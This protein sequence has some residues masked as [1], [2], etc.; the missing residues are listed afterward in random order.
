MNNRIAIGV[1]ASVIAAVAAPRVGAAAP[2]TAP[3]NASAWNGVWLFDRADFH[4]VKDGVGQWRA[5]LSTVWDSQVTIRD[6]AFIFSHWY[7]ISKDVK[8]TIILDPAGP[9]SVDLKIESIDLGE[10]FAGVSYPAC[11]LPGIYQIEGDRLLVCC[12]FGSNPRRPSDFRAATEGTLEGTLV[13]Q[14]VKADADF[15]GFSKAV[16][17]SV[18]DPGGKPVPG[19]SICIHMG[20]HQGKN[21][22]DKMTYGYD[23]IAKTDANGIAHVSYDDLR[24]NNVLV[25]DEAHK[26]MGIASVTPVSLEKLAVTVQLHPECLLTGKIERG[27][28]PGGGENSMWTNVILEYGGEQ[29]AACES[30]SGG[31]ESRG[32]RAHGTVDA[33]WPIALQ[34]IRGHLGVVVQERCG[35]GRVFF[36]DHE[37]RRLGEPHAL[38][39]PIEQLRLM[40]GVRAPSPDANRRA[41]QHQSQQKAVCAFPPWRRSRG[42]FQLQ[43]SRGWGNRGHLLTPTG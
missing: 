1:L 24:K 18:I 4:W 11:T 28:L 14:F 22:K 35:G 16:A 15:K 10:M 27:V 8:G 40:P 6:G 41:Q 19:A 13:I 2:S 32:I 39:L 12:Q 25:R 31:L 43:W 37:I 7:G 5:M 42:I 17:I 3:T 26:Q 34:G 30:F 36:V 21:P 23:D 29:I 38:P 33:E 20:R 9:G